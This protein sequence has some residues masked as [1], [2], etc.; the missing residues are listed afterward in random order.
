MR[1]AFL[2]QDVGSIYGAERATLDL[3]EGLRSAG[4]DARMLLIEEKRLALRESSLQREIE[5]RQIPVGVIPCRSAFSTGLVQAIRDYIAREQVEVLHAVGYKA[6]LHGLLGSSW[7][8]RAKLVATVHGWLYRP[9]PKERFYGWLDIFAMKRMHA[10]VALSQFYQSLLL[11]K[12]LRAQIVH[13]IPSGLPEDRL[14]P[15]EGSHVIFEQPSPFSIG[16]AG[17]LS[18]EKNHALLLRAVRKVAGKGHDVRLL[19]AGDGPLKEALERQTRAHGLSDRVELTGY[20]P[21]N[22]FFRRIHA[23]VLCSRIENLPYSVMEAMAWCRPVI[24]TRVG[25]VPDLVDENET[26]FLV[27]RG[28]ENALADRIE[29]MIRNP[30]RACAMGVAGRHKLESQFL[31]A[32]VIQKH[33]DLYRALL[34]SASPKTDNQ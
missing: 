30:L 17:R 24:A 6:N 9:D 34:D 11:R 5:Q 3:V 22:D 18:W 12:G 13:L 15:V 14:P 32:R 21:V 10:V 2:L 7:G 29:R 4:V 27:S 8:R 1:I 16:I 31:L 28:D 33:L 20:I 23:F 26:G 19:I 25:G